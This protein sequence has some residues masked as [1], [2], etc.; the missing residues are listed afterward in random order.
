VAPP[1]AGS[2]LEYAQP[3]TA[4]ASA[5]LVV[6]TADGIFPDDEDIPGSV[7]PGGVSADLDWDDE[8]A[9]THV[10][11]RDDT[12]DL[13]ADLAG[14]QGPYATEEADEEPVVRREIAGAAAL[15]SQSGRAAA[16]L[17]QPEPPPVVQPFSVPADAAVEIPAPA[18]LPREMKPAEAS[19]PAVSPSMPPEPARS[20]YAPS[21]PPTARSSN[22]AIYILSGVA[23]V[24][25]VAAVVFYFQHTST[26]TATIAVSGPGGQPIE[27][28]KVYIDGQERCQFTPCK[29]EDLSPGEKRIRVVAGDQ[30]G[31]QRVTIEG[32]GKHQITVAVAEAQATADAKPGRATLKMSSKLADVRVSVNGV[33][34]GKLP[35]ELRDLE[36]GTLSLKFEGGGDRYGVRS[37]SVEL[38]PGETRVLDDI[39]LP[40]VKVKVTFELVTKGAD[41][42]L[43]SSKTKR[44]ESLDF[45]GKTLSKTLDTSESW[46]VEATKKNHEPFKKEL[47]FDDGKS[48]QTV[49]IELDEKKVATAP[50]TGPVGTTTAPETKPETGGKATINV[51]ALPVAKA[52]VDGRPIGS[53]PAS[54]TVSPG[55][56]SVVCFHKKYGRKS[57]SVT[58]SAGQSKTVICRFKKKSD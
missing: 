8:D 20:S 26:G 41:V 13:F 10:F 30:M 2:D 46:T 51:S 34:K 27:T 32:G 28:A 57:R 3:A 4:E 29:I 52:I 38:K 40:L 55:T 9:E 23:L 44:A 39:M 54:A 19:V 36:P 18:P 5:D 6:G 25:V 31:E 43:I 49:A 48:E 35:L 1:E 7:L 22:L 17:P 14:R 58:V 15:L 33:D 11:D 37:S 45:K 42:K 21:M 53:T 47:S 50:T 16:P 56:H 12:E 24:V